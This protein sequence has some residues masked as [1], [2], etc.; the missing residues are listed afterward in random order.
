MLNAPG[1][2]ASILRQGTLGESLKEDDDVSRYS[3]HNNPNNANN[4]NNQQQQ[5]QQ[6]Q[7][8]PP[9]QMPTAM[10]SLSMQMPQQ[11]QQQQ[12][13]YPT[14][15]TPAVM[16][17]TV[18]L[19]PGQQVPQHHSQLQPEQINQMMAAL[20]QMSAQS[21]VAPQVPPTYE[22]S[23]ADEWRYN[24]NYAFFAPTAPLGECLYAETMRQA[25]AAEI[26]TVATRG[27]TTTLYTCDVNVPLPSDAVVQSA[28][29]MATATAP[30][31]DATTAAP[32]PPVLFATQPAPS[33]A[34]AGTVPQLPQPQPQPQAASAPHL[35]FETLQEQSP[36]QKEQPQPAQVV[37]EP[38]TP[39][40]KMP[41]PSAP[42]ETPAKEA[43]KEQPAD[44]VAT[45]QPAV[46]AAVTPTSNSPSG[47]ASP[48]VSE[49]HKKKNRKGKSKG[50]SKSKKEAVLA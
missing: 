50:K 25:D 37:C 11:Q 14:T 36:P 45:E 49:E 22:E 4:R 40:V 39:D 9:S 24:P 15:Y 12:P 5:Q 21:A 26:N 42:T 16:A 3:V 30:A 35:T 18:S 20:A 38:I 8:L 7:L 47:S 44:E 33:L 48:A 43:E 1:T 13:L 19:G 32:A 41:V 17:A 31:A 23:T 28:P 2:P 6:Q 46:E 29:M 10:P 27:P 34:C